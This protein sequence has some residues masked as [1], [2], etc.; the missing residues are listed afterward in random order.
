MAHIPIET[1]P[2]LEA[3]I[4]LPMLLIVLEKDHAQIEA[5]QFKLK[6]PYI[7]LIDEAR[8]NAEEDL[9]KTKAYLK[10]RSLKV[11]KGQR[12]E[13]FTEYHFHYHQLM[14]VRRYSNIRLRNHV[15]HL[16]N[17][18]LNKAS[19]VIQKDIH[20]ESQSILNQ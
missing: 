11:V 10:N 13:M 3:A 8:R 6:R 9:K 5:G 17:F 16:L 7:F 12:D 15:E 14:E 1:V 20:F 4:Y 19:N 2:Y 18:Y